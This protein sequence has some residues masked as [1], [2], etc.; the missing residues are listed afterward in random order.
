MTNSIVPS[1]EVQEKYGFTIDSDLC[2]VLTSSEPSE[3][4]ATKYIDN[5]ACPWCGKKNLSLINE[6]FFRC[7]C[8][9][10][11]ATGNVQAES[12]PV[13]SKIE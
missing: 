10:F 1:R 3:R 4:I 12:I 11:A 5:F 7:T 9:F 8:G 2:E 13:L 6:F